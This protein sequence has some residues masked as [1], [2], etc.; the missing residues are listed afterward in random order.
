M[1]AATS[2]TF[3][4]LLKQIWPQSDIYD[5]LYEN[6]PAYA[7]V[8]K[9]TDFFEKTRNIAV[10][11]GATQGAGAD[12]TLAK[13][14]K[15]P[16]KEV[17]FQITTVSYYSLFSVT[18]KL[19]RQSQNKR[20]AIAAALERESTLAL[21]TWKRDMGYL[22]FGNGGGALGS[23]ASGQGSA[24]VTLNT[25][26]DVRKFEPNMLLQVASDDGSAATPAG[27]RTGFVTVSSADRLNGTVTIT[28][29]NW[30][31]VGNIPNVQANDSIFRAGN[32]A[33][34]I[35]GLGAWVPSSNPA[36]NDSFFGVNRSQ[37]VFRLGGVRKT[38]TG[39]SPREGLM[40]GAME[41]FN[42]GGAPTH[43]FRHTADYLNL[44]LELQSAGNLV[45][46]KELAEKPTGAVFG[47]PFEAVA[48]MGPTGPI[49]IFPDYNC[50]QSTSFMLQF[51]TWTLAGT[52]DF[53]YIDAQ[54]G[55]R[56]LRE[57]SA[58][59]YEGRIVGDLQL[60]TEAPG[61]NVRM[62]L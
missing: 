14:A 47:I 25:A 35:K 49:K 37:D 46:M 3:D 59:A 52:G 43:E 4:A 30:S 24:T 10:G 22:L 58:D 34:V 1:S 15:A 40:T 53:P 20:G 5:L 39:L 18:R 44:Q 36:G 8:R 23:I 21:K 61:Y 56:I 11:F 12:F 33:S 9:Q 17:A 28:S 62:T 16:S 26:S 57:E 55:N 45:V 7:L 29:G 50:P 6:M 48:V 2:T 51:D 19:I 13:T 42:N 60:Y 41:A 31:D 54:D 27:V 32:Y 38:V